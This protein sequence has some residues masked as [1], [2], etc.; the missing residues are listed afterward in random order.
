[1]LGDLDTRQSETYRSLLVRT[2]KVKK[3]KLLRAIK[4][5]YEAAISIILLM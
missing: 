4:F 1:M 3:K 2:K 5:G